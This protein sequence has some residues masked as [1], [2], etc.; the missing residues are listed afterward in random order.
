MDINLTFSINPHPTK[1]QATVLFSGYS[2]TSP[3]HQVGPLVHDYY[4][5]HYVL[6]GKGVFRCMG[7]EYLLEQGSAFCIFPGELVSYDADP[8]EPWE[9][10]WIGFGGSG[11]DELL[12]GLGLS[13]HTPISQKAYNRRVHA[14]FRRIERTLQQ[15]EPTCEL[16]AGGWFRLILAMLAPARLPVAETL[17]L[18][19]TEAKRQVEQAIRWLTLQYPQHISIAQMAQALG[20]HRT[21]LS[22]IFK[23]ETGLPPMS[24]LLKIRMERAGLLLQEPLTVEQVAASVG[25]GDALYF[26]R[27]F[28]KWYGVS[29]SEYRKN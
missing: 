18:P 6:A 19:E 17:S 7:K 27:Q 14:L 28:K 5:L 3:D 15:G 11:T 12:S 22:K 29:P 25:F 1:G 9:Y 23:R 8:T 10:R 16:Q 13:V 20:Y 24:F 4:L 26:S 2:Q 21:H